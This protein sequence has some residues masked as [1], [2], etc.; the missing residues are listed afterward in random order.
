MN[1]TS[2][3]SLPFVP[4]RLLEQ[5]GVDL[6]NSADISRLAAVWRRWQNHLCGRTFSVEPDHGAVCVWLNPAVEAEVDEAWAARPSEGFTLH[7]LALELCMTAVRH[8]LP[9][10][11][12]LRAGCAPIPG[13]YP[14]QRGALTRYGAPVSWDEGS[15]GAVAPALIRRYAVLTWL[16][17]RGGC[18]VCALR[19][20]CGKTSASD[21]DELE[22]RG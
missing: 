3:P 6:F 2:F 8:L 16:P 21:G 22:G 13:F 9:Q 20:G 10:A 5:G 18:E 1:A 7:T 19:G 12:G 15:E 4:G 17:F 14:A 11:A